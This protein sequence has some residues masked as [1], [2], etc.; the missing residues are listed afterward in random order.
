[1]GLMC[2][3]TVIGI[4]LF[5]CL[6]SSSEAVQNV[7]RVENPNEITEGSCTGFDVGWTVT[8]KVISRFYFPTFVTTRLCRG[9]CSMDNDLL[10]NQ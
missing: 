9:V 3:P 1:M 8:E 10:T 4:K 6:L 7:L 2:L 5:L